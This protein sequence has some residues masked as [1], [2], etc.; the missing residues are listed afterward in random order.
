M[1]PSELEEVLDFQPFQPFRLILASGDVIDALR[2]PGVN[3]TG[4]SLAVEETTAAGAR[5]LRLISIPNIVLL[6]PL[7]PQHEAPLRGAMQ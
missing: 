4:L 3:V 5:R 1:G 6:E 2:R 7:P